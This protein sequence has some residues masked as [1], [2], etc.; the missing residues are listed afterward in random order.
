MQ[1]NGPAGVLLVLAVIL[2]LTFAAAYSGRVVTS[3][4]ATGTRGSAHIDTPALTRRL[5]DEVAPEM[6]TWGASLAGGR[7][8]NPFDPNRPVCMKACSN[9]GVPYTGHGCKTFY[10]CRGG[11]T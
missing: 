9:P 10:M 11:G 3:H 5:E 2:L 7:R 6:M 1:V 8:N 4:A